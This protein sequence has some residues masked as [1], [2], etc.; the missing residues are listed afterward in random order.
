MGPRSMDGS[1]AVYSAD[2]ELFVIRGKKTVSVTDEYSSV[3]ISDNGAY[4][5]VLDDDYVLT[6]YNAKNGES[7]EIAEDVQS[8]AM[9][10]N[11]K[12]IAYQVNDGGDVIGFVYKGQESIE[13]GEDIIPLTI[14]N[15]GKYIYCY[16]RDK[17]ALC[18][19]D[20]KGNST[21]IANDFYMGYTFLF[22]YRK[23]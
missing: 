23:V 12:T 17:D 2:D 7:V 10:P 15:S 9:S 20:T 13:L 22:W 4:V 6:V 14:D 21:K 16:D 1:V 3:A 11:G 5:A 19:M 8:F 18:V